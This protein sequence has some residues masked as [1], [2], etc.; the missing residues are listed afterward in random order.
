[1]ISKSPSPSY[2][3]EGKNVTLE[4]TYTL[5]GTIGSAWF[6]IV[7]D[8]GNDI[9]I[10]TRLKNG[11]VTLQAKFKARFRADITDTRAELTILAVQRS[12][13]KTYKINILSTGDGSI[14]ETIC[15]VVNSKY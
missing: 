12:D 15:L 11:A 3:V 2:A 13:E 8:Q 4:W 1:M 6:A 5:V 7:Y 9:T 10:A 14:S